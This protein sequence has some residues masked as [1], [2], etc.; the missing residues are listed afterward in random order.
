MTTPPSSPPQPRTA[1]ERAKQIVAAVDPFPDVEQ[2]REAIARAIQEA[3]DEARAEGAQEL[4]DWIK[5]AAGDEAGYRRLNWW[6]KRG[7]EAIR[8]R[9]KE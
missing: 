7:L 1:E 2:L 8:A 5:N 6:L 3:Q 9:G 4:A